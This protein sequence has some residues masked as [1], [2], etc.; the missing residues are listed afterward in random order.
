MADIHIEDFCKDIAK[1]LLQLFNS[2][3]RPSNVYVADIAGDDNPDE[4]GLHSERHLACF[5]AMVWLADEG[6]IRYVDTI[7]QEGIDQAV[8]THRTLCLLSR[9]CSDR[10]LLNDNEYLEPASPT[11]SEQD[12][13]LPAETIL[14]RKTHINIIRAALASGS[15]TRI[16]RVIQRLVIQ[17]C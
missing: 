12:I 5:G 6:Y 10:H 13:S 15:S 7:R 2:F 17:A 3:P 16:Y 14:D 9:V 4:F 11:E 1:I 8:L